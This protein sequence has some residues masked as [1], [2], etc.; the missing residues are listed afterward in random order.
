M[1]SVTPPN[2]GNIVFAEISPDARVEAQAAAEVGLVESRINPDTLEHTP[3]AP[4]S[5]VADFATRH[6]VDFVAPTEGAVY[7][8]RPVT[9]PG[10]VYSGKPVA[11]APAVYR[12]RL[13]GEGAE[14]QTVRARAAAFIGRL[15]MKSA[16]FAVDNAARAG[17]MW[18]A[19]RPAR[20][21][22]ETIDAKYD[23]FGL[24]DKHDASA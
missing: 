7:E 2:T 1:S 13:V 10:T 14:L 6:T 16:D 4:E 12:G 17:R 24:N 11:A 21:Q 9:A 20:S 15:A 5:P 19:I 23:R 3:L 18:R 22:A 8:G